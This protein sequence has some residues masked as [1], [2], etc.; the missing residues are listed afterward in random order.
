[1]EYAGNISGSKPHVRKYN[2]NGGVTIHAGEPAETGDADDNYSGCT[3]GSTTASVSIVGCASADAT[4]TAAQATTGNNVQEVSVVIN[5]DAMWRTKFSGGT[6]ED[7]ALTLITQTAASTTGLV[8]TGATDEFL[9]W[10]YEGA[11]VGAGWR[12]A[13][14]AAAVTTAF[15]YDIAVGDTFCQ[16]P[17]SIGSQT[18]FPQLTAA[19]T[20]ID[21]SAAVDADNDN[22]VAVDMILRDVTDDGQN[23]SYALLISVNH[24]FAPSVRA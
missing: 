4:S 9:L 7:T 5:P 20:Q 21:A 14:G 23:N 24:A 13:S 22:F 1:M 10:C 11:N 3:I 6:A 18:Q 17:I 2:V 12:I 8:V 15:P 19:L 16:V